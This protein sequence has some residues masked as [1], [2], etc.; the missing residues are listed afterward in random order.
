[1]A[2]WTSP[3][4]WVDDEL[5]TATLLNTHLRDNQ[6]YL[7]D[8]MAIGTRVYNNASVSIAQST[9][10]AIPFNAELYDTDNIHDLS[11]NTTRLT[12]K[13]AGKYAIV[14]HVLWDV[15][16]AGRWYRLY[17]RLNGSTNIAFKDEYWSPSSDLT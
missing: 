15:I 13:T 2:S 17:I 10:V 16:N 7:Y 5:V 9:H 3:R 11:T 4:T 12:C 8:A 14:G 6:Q 1:M